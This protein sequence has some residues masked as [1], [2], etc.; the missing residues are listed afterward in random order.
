MQKIEENI[1]LLQP[2]LA[3]IRNSLNVSRK[4]VRRRRAHMTQH[5]SHQRR[6]SK[7]LVILLSSSTSNPAASNFLPSPTWDTRTSGDRIRR[8]TARARVAAARAHRASVSFASTGLTSAAAASRRTRTTSASTNTVEFVATLPAQGAR[9][10]A[11]KLRSRPNAKC[12]PHGT[13]GVPCL[14]RNHVCVCR[15][16]E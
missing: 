11:A 2:S 1:R 12:A 7:S 4:G 13:Q 5:S 3:F 8:A 10:H 9:Q 14:S 16:S 6:S 15:T